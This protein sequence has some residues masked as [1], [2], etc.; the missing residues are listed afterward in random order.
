MIYKVLSDL[1]NSVILQFYDI[2]LK[3]T[4]NFHAQIIDEVFQK[5]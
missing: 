3:K 4:I 1:D 5:I 2:L